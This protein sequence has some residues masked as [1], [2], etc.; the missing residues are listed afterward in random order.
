[1]NSMEKDKT[2][3]IGAW[4]QEGKAVVGIEFGSTRIK[5]V[6]IGEDFSPIAGG[7]FTW[8][9]HL[10]HGIWT[11]HKDEIF[12]GLR[13]CYKALKDQVQERYGV[14]LKKLRGLGISGM[15]HGYLA[16][17]GER[18]LVPFRTWRNTNTGEA[19]RVL[20]ELFDFN[21][22][23]R[24]S[25]AH[26]YQ[27]VLNQEEH[28]K[29]V[30]FI[31][32]L[33]GYISRCLGGGKSLGIGDAAG[34][35]PIKDASR[36]YDE[37]MLDQFDALVGG[38]Y[39]WRIREIL[40][41]VALAGES[42]GTLTQEGAFLLDPSG[43]LE[44]GAL[45]SP[46]EGDAGTGMAATNAVKK[47]TGNVSAGTSIFAMLVLEKALKK[48]HMEIDMVTTPAGDPVAMVHANNCSSDI[49]AW[50]G[51]F[52]E[53]ALGMGV[54]ATDDAFYTYLFQK[55]LEADP[56]CG[57]LLSYGYLS[58][59]SIT[60]LEK[61]RPLFVRLPEAKLNLANFMQT[62]IVSAFGAIKIGMDI[63]TV[64]EG[65][66]VDHLVGHGG[67]FKTKEVAQGL[68]AD[69]L[70]IP[71]TVMENAGEGGPWGEALLTAY[72]FEK[73]KASL[74]DFLE[75]KVF[76]SGKSSQRLPQKERGEGLEK[77][78]Q[79]YQACLEVEKQAVKTLQ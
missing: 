69:S 79:R 37:T 21:I 34:M 71:V 46:P 67:I 30:D 3:A 39:P 11:Y 33:S 27:A 60:G 75:Q 77:F 41:K 51:L 8:E 66:A 63:L 72:L 5:A 2:K 58:G 45:L 7:S 28:V 65:V 19:A 35:F 52:K 38:Q 78:F 55:A 6:M 42:V 10:E 57:G 56:D 50:V 32:T 18:L 59:E 48:R 12:E 13:M 17:K 15:M 4:I 49:N 26:L 1:M 54:K 47:R 74:G 40:P 44:P 62:H 9:N 43:D 16:F 23:E 14:T 24:W 22:P 61:G 29:D 31:T 36:D 20:S 73:E 70:N 76:V 64:Q 25:I 68:L 53:F